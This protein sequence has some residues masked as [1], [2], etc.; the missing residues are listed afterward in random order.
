MKK[1]SF[2]L[3]ALGLVFGLFAILG[4]AV[5]AQA[6]QVLQF[7]IPFDFY[8]GSEKFAAGKYEIKKVN[9]SVYVLR[10]AGEK[11]GMLITTSG[12]A[13]QN[14][15]A[16]LEQIV[17]NRYGE[18]YFLRKI[19]AKRMASGHEVAESKFERETRRKEGKLAKNNSETKQVSVNAIK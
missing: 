4:T 6:Q 12:D 3:F 19:Y 13:E 7:D 1:Q 2:K 5:S 9:S 16:K 10:N 8:A 15:E 14:R 11:D 17:F 18:T